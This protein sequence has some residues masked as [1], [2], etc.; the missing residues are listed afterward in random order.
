MLTDRKYSK[1]GDY[2]CIQCNRAG[3]KR[4]EITLYKSGVLVAHNFGML[5]EH[6]SYEVQYIL[7]LFVKNSDSLFGASS[8]EELLDLGL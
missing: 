4:C 6:F 1:H 7:H 2:V 5:K 8:L 3:G